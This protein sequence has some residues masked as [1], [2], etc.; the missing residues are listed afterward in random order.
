MIQT[1][2]NR[3]VIGTN[4]VERPRLI[5]RLDEALNGRFTLISAPAGYGKTTLVLQ[6][7]DL[8]RMPTAWFAVDETDSD[9]DRFL[10]YVVAAVR[11]VIPEFGSDIERLL[12]APQLPPPEHLADAMVN[13]LAALEQPLLIVFDDY[14]RFTS[15]TVNEIMTRMLQY[16]PEKL[17]VLLLTRKD[18]PLPLGLWSSRQ[19]LSE[20]RAADLRFTRQETQAFLEKRLRKRPSDQT[21]DFLNGRTEGWVAALQLVQ[22]SL[23]PAEDPDC[24]VRRFSESDR[25][26]TDYLMDE[27]VSRQP[28]EVIDFL[29]ITAHFERFCVPLCDYLLSEHK[30]APNTHGIINRL[31]KENL[32]LVALDSERLWYRYHHLFRSLLKQHLK[33]KRSPERI[34]QFHRRAGKWFAGQ[35]LVEEALRHFLSAGDVDTAAALLEDNMHSAIDNDLSR[36]TL[37]RWL[38]MFPKSAVDQ[39]PALQVATVYQKMFR[40]DYI[41][42]EP[43]LDKAEALLRNPSF[44]IEET[45]R[46][47]LLGDI[48]LQRAFFFYWRGNIEAALRHTRQSL[49]VISKEHNYAHTMTILY[50]TLAQAL[51]GRRGEALQLIAEALIEDCAEGSRNAGVFLLIRAVIH[52][53]AGDLNAVEESARQ[54][55]SLH[56]T[57]PMPDYWYAYAIYYLAY[58]AYERNLLDTAENYFG[59]IEQ[60]RYAISTRLYQDALIGLALSTWAKGETVRAGQYTVAAHSFAREMSSPGSLQVANSFQTRMAILSGNVVDDPAKTTPH[61]DD[62]SKVFLEIPSLTRAEYQVYRNTPAECAAALKSVEE[63]LQQAKQHHNTRQVIQFLAVKSIALKCAGR[64]NEALEALEETLQMAEPLGFVRTFLDRGPPMAELLMALLEKSPENPYLHRLLDAFAVERPSERCMTLSSGEESGKNTPSESHATTKPRISEQ[65]PNNV[66]TRR[67]IEILPLLA[68]G[69]SNKE[70]AT[71]LYI[72]PVTV[73]THLQ[74]IYQKLNVNNRIEALK[75]VRKMGIIID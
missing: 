55:L 36:R 67:E 69:L 50:M 22:L 39:H 52:H 8:H 28:S 19:W 25:S 4:S 3:P 26:I 53:Y 63:G 70:I 9:P 56:E 64:L 72:A 44:P 75:K 58:S 34:S 14:H 37:G 24:L 35:G 6:W 74:N 29:A 49:G 51:S 17:H 59:Q 38:D 68:E 13:E 32:F 10:N 5:S 33:E 18:P 11:T 43:M 57:V 27:V 60:M 66:L 48:D 46:L 40:W 16:L 71:R 62:S 41:S 47:K 31:E 23:S 61:E 15:Q 45:R 1:K 42:M 20:L 2:L 30:A 12:S 73:K 65:S 21:V 54:V 7:L